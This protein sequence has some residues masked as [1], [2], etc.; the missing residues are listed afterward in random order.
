MDQSWKTEAADGI[1]RFHL[2]AYRDI[3]DI[4]LFLE[5]TA[6]YINSCFAPLETLAITP[7]MI[8]NYVKRRLIESPAKKL[9]SRQQIAQLLFITVAKMVL[10][11]EELQ[12]ILQL[13][14]RS[15]STQIAY[16]Y[17]TQELENVLQY[18]FG[19]KETLDTVGVEHSEEKTLLRNAIIA[20][21]HRLYLAACLRG[22]MTRSGAELTGETE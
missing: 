2:P 5:Q 6:Q 10:S 19:L 13:Q 4:G 16:D 15:Y 1:A 8:S 21:A 22:Y 18:V 14:Q 12:A 11:L 3:P 7:S 9:Y 17:F 20:V